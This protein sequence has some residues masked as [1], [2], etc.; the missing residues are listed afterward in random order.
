MRTTIDIDDDVLQAAK[1]LAAVA[2]KTTG[3]VVS[4]LI[5]RALARR[6]PAGGALRRGPR[7]PRLGPR[8]VRGPTE[9][10]MGQLT[11]DRT[12]IGQST[13]DQSISSTVVPGIGRDTLQVI[14]AVEE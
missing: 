5:R 13:F 7:A 9:P 14:T 2:H 3:Q 8:L 1:E 10:R 6:E 11:G 4:D 12:A